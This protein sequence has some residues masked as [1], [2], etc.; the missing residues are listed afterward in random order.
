MSE[1]TLPPDVG[2]QMFANRLRKNL[3]H[4]SRWARREGVHCYRLS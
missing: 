3:K 2:A 4:L 1:N